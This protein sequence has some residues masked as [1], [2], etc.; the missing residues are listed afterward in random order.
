MMM[1]RKLD[2]RSR[3]SGIQTFLQE[4]RHRDNPEKRGRMRSAGKINMK[5]TERAK[6]SL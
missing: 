4:G 1:E 6:I 2:L 5:S 3:G